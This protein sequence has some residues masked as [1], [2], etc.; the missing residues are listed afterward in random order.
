VLAELQLLLEVLGRL[1]LLLTSG[2]SKGLPLTLVVRAGCANAV[3][4]DEAAA[5]A[6]LEALG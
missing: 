5:R 1:A 4:C 2:A 6:A 3:V